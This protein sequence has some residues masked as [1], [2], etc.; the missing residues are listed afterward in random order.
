M[1][2]LATPPDCAVMYPHTP[3]YHMVPQS[4]WSSS[5]AQG[6]TKPLVAWDKAEKERQQ[7]LQLG[8]SCSPQTASLG[9]TSE[10]KS[11]PAPLAAWILIAFS[12]R[13]TK[14]LCQ[15]HVQIVTCKRTCD[16][17]MK[18]A[19]MTCWAMIWSACVFESL[20]HAL[21]PV[22]KISDSLFK[23]NSQSVSMIHYQ[24]IW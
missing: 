13:D 3:H 24:H 18:Y 23:V 22:L 11:T 17:F 14:D 1:S 10:R 9:R 6:D 2:V 8:S 20:S 4:T 5:A 15:Q 16:T 21:V 7:C 19:N 12:C